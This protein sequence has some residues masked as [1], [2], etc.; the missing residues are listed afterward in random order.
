V[1]DPAGGGVEDAVLKNPGEAD[2]VLPTELA[3]PDGIFAAD[4]VNGFRVETVAPGST[5]LRREIEQVLPPGGRMVCG[6]IRREPA[7]PVTARKP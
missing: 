2:W 6:W 3:L 1:F 5:R 7:P 4:G